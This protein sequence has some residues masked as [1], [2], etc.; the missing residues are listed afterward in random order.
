MDPRLLLKAKLFLF[1]VFYYAIFKTFDIP[2]LAPPPPDYFKPFY[3]ILD[4]TIVYV[5]LLYISSSQQVLHT[6]SACQIMLSASFS[7]VLM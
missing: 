3:A 7:F 2:T 6:M 1:I 4:V 5:Q